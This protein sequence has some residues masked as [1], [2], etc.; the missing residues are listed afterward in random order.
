[1]SVTLDLAGRI[2]ALRY[3]SFPAA[4]IDW[5]KI[6]IL[7]TIGVALAGTTERGRQAQPGDC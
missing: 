6:A 4:A 1:M 3:E 7:D 5:A 2:H